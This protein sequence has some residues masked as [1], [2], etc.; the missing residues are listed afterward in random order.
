M[1]DDYLARTYKAMGESL[2]VDDSYFEQD[3]RFFTLDQTLRA[4]PSG[5]ILDMGCGQGAL[6]ARLSSQHEV[7]GLEWDEGA[8][9][10]AREKGLPVERVDLN[11]AQSIPFAPP[12]DAIICSEV[13]EHLLNPR[14]AFKLAFQ[15]LKP[16]GIFVVTV[17]NAVPLFARIA[18]LLGRT[19]NWLHYPSADTEITGHIRFYTLRSLRHLAEQEGFTV[20]NQRGLSWRMNGRFWEGLFYWISRLR[21]ASNLPKAAMLLDAAFGRAFPGLS[22]GLM[23][24]LEKPGNK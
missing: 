3:A 16:G 8:L 22:P 17:P 1:N 11:D 24:N 4:L 9:R 12:F 19:V 15:H 14:N 2:V 18:I 7:F 10:I 21:R 23:I 20:I 5:R 6:I 13:C